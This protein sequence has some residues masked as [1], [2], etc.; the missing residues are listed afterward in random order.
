MASSG[1]SVSEP[2][3]I[4]LSTPLK[5][6]KRPINPDPKANKKEEGKPTHSICLKL[7]AIVVGTILAKLALDILFSTNMKAPVM[8]SA[9]ELVVMTENWTNY[10]LTTLSGSPA[11]IQVIAPCLALI[12]AY[13]PLQLLPDDKTFIMAYVMLVTYCFGRFLQTSS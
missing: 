5:P 11:F 1:V 2:L 4:E 3:P 12:V 10:D 13:V 8:K 6:S 7:F 9:R